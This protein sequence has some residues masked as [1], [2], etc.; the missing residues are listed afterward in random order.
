MV[1]AKYWL[2]YKFLLRRARVE[3]LILSIDAGTQSV[4][5]IVFNKEGELL[6]KSQQ[7]LPNYDAPKPGWA[8]INPEIYW[9]KI[10]LAIREVITNY[11]ELTAELGG[12][13]LTT[14]RSTVINVDQ[15]GRPL[16]PAILWLDQRRQ[17]NLPFLPGVWG[18]IFKTAGLKDTVS[19]LMSQAEANW[20]RV[21]EPEVWQK[22]YKYLFL[23][24]YLY[25]KFTG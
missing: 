19:Y 17:E 16:R 23:S 14:Q 5:A 10:L 15:D 22:T 2:F 7:F 13:V 6:V 1:K 21:N 8:E 9:D 4:R 18:L 20:I 3:K 25:Y 11:P 24:G 12:L